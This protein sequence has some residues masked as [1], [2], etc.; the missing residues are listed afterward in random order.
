MEA[1]GVDRVAAHGEDLAA[2]SFGLGAPAAHDAPAAGT[3]DYDALVVTCSCPVDLAQ[4]RPIGHLGGFS[5]DEEAVSRRRPR[6]GRFRPI[7]H[8]FPQKSR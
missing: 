2:A 8:P 6:P 3:L 4:T 7:G 1:G 5:L